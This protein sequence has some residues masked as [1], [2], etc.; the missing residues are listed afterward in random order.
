MQATYYFQRMAAS[1]LGKP[2]VVL[3]DPSVTMLMLSLLAV[4]KVE[5]PRVVRALPMGL[6]AGVVPGRCVIANLFSVAK[7]PKLMR[8][9]LWLLSW[10]L[11]R[12]SG[13]CCANAPIIG[14]A[15]DCSAKV[16]L[17]SSVCGFTLATCWPCAAATRRTDA[18]SVLH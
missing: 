3:A 9:L 6:R 18:S 10:L 17:G 16:G 14:V 15:L 12:S 4:I 2:R 8:W 13:G 7:R 1:S 11:V 5:P